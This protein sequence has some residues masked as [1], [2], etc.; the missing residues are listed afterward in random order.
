V[1]AREDAIAAILLGAIEARVAFPHLAAVRHADAV[2]PVV[3]RRAALHEALLAEPDS[4]E[5]VPG[6][7]DVQQLAA[8]AEEQVDAVHKA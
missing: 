8:A 5:L 2:E 7:L 1:V 4:V 6:R 3:S